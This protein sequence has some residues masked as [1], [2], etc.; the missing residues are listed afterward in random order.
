MDFI[1]LREVRHARATRLF[2]SGWGNVLRYPRI[3]GVDGY[4]QSVPPIPR[5]FLEPDPEFPLLVLVDVRPGLDRCCALAGVSVSGDQSFH[6]SVPDWVTADEFDKPYWILCNDGRS[7]RARSP[8]F[9][10]TDFCR[11]RGVAGLQAHEGLF[12]AIQ[13]P[14]TVDDNVLDLVGSMASGATTACLGRIF[15][16]LKLTHRQID[17]PMDDCGAPERKIDR[18]LRSA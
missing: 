2:G 12:L 6:P 9:N 10:T 16:R 14:S 3:A 8:R 13:H 18:R 17:C 5:E 1:D 7:N 4:L 15:G 11:E